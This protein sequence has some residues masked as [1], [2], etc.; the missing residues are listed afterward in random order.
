MFLRDSA[1]SNIP[2]NELLSVAPSDDPAAVED[3][4]AATRQ[5]DKRSDS[6]ISCR[7]SRY[8]SNLT[9]GIGKKIHTF[10]SRNFSAA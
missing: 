5:G 8:R 4:L 3:S 2:A 6:G 1:T 9:C 7:V 10:S